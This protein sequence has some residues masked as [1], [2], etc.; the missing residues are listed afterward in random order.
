MYFHHISR[1]PRSIQAGL[2]CLECTLIQSLCIHIYLD[3]D[4]P[5][6]VITLPHGSLWWWVPLLL[7]TLNV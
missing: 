4:I 1:K 7:P 6:V 5:S 2:S 3:K